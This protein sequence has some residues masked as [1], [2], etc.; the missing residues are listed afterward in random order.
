MGRQVFIGYKLNLNTYY[1]IYYN[2]NN[3]D[4]G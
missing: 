1:N 4:F 3:Q 2:I